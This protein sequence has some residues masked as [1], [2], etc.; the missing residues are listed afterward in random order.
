MDCGIGPSI[1]NNTT[2]PL[3]LLKEKINKNIAT[4]PMQREIPKGK[5]RFVIYDEVNQ[6]YF[7]EGFNIDWPKFSE[8]FRPNKINKSILE[9]TLT[10]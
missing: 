1:F 7:T 3:V 6:L 4:Y 8:V 10:A 2:I 5:Y 9:V